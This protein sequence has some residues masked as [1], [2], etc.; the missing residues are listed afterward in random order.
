MITKLSIA[1][2]EEIIK[3]EESSFDNPWTRNQFTDPCKKFNKYLNFVYNDTTKVIGYLISEII[4]DEVHLY[5]IVV[6]KNNQNNKVGSKLLKFMIQ[7]CKKLNKIR[8][9]LEVDSQNSNAIKLYKKFGFLT[10]GTRNKYYGNNDAI[11]MDLGL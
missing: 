4:L 6:S 9:C 11:L 7:E 1:N 5:K 10:V 8:V 2:I 3:I